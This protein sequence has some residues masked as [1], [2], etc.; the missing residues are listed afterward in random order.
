MQVV[1]VGFA[2]VKGARH[3]THHRATVAADGVVGDRVFCLVDPATDRCLRTVQHPELLRARAAWDGS[4]LTVDLPSG[5]HTGL[6]AATGEVRTVDYW[7]RPT[8]VE[9]V[10][11]PWAAAYTEHLGRDVLLARA[12]PGDVVYGGP[13]TLVSTDA[14]ARLGDA[15]DPARFRA[16]L[17]LSGD[18]PAP[19]DRVAVGSAVLEV[20]RRV[21]RCAVVDHHP[22]TGVRDARLLR[23]LPL[24][25]GEPVFGVEADVVTPGTVATGDPASVTAR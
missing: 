12:R 16:T 10:A 7:G 2:P 5:S 18:D 22:L 9:V 1:R 23:A 13:V 15:V 19:G 25:A 4:T 14:L 3:A 20:R 24:E 21:P 8:P 11:G 6:P 17:L